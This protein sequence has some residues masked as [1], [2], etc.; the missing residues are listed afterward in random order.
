MLSFTLVV[1]IRPAV[2]F[3]YLILFYLYF[4]LS[5]YPKA[6]EEAGKLAFLFELFWAGACLCVDCP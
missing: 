4:I 6:A 1:Q 2:S 3:V 5:F